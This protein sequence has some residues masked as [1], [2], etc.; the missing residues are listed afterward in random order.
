MCSFWSCRVVWDWQNSSLNLLI[1]KFCTR[2]TNIKQTPQSRRQTFHFCGFFANE[3]SC[4]ANCPSWR[5]QPSL[6]CFGTWSSEP[7]PCLNI[8]CK[9]ALRGENQRLCFCIIKCLCFLVSWVQNYYHPIFPVDLLFLT[10]WW[11]CEI[12]T[13][14][15]FELIWESEQR[16]IELKKRG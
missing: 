6:T 10:L 3:D 14:Y 2:T 16:W 4:C 9:N 13:K 1:N 8:I 11:W 7:T 15:K 5:R 12:K